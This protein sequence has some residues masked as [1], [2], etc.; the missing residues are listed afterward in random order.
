MAAASY[1]QSTAAVLCARCWRDGLFRLGSA[2]DGPTGYAG[3]PDAHPQQPQDDLPAKG[4]TVQA[5]EVVDRLVLL[6]PDLAEELRDRGLLRL[7]LGEPLL[8]PPTSPPTPSACPPR[9][10]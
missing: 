3:D 5:L 7:A 4:E 6:R 1:P 10:S 8:P 2:L 9:R